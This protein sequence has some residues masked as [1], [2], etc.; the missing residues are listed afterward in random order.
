MRPLD[1]ILVLDLT[2]LLPGAAAT[3]WLANFGAEVIKVEQPGSGDY[4]RN[5]FSKGEDPIF[6]ATNRGKKSI[7]I[8][9]KDPR[10]RDVFLAL[11]PKADILIEGFRPRVM[12]RLGLGF[13]ELRKRNPSLICVALTGYG[14]DGPYSGM[15][16]HDINYLAL[17]GVL[18]LIGAKDGPPVIPGVQIADLAG[19][20]MQAVIGVLLALQARERTGRGQRVEISMTDGAAALLAVPLAGYQA[21]GR[22]PERGDELLSGRFACYNVY[23]ARDGRWVSVGAL[24]PKFWANLCRELALEHLVGEQFAAEPRRSEIKAA[25]AA[26]FRTRDAE[27]WFALL[28]GKDCCVAPVRNVAE[29][30]KDAHFAQHPFGLIPALSETPGRAGDRAPA[31]GEHTRETLRWAGISR[32]TL[33]ELQR[34]GVIQ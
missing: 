23:Q 9:L 17:A 16:G 8:D 19:G 6:T 7:A 4:A 11:V 32:E 33:E 13:E 25:V 12:E 1:G 26:V 31:L 20:S 21:T 22:A 2:R 15:A 24:E 29:A 30:V 5:L 14:S 18:D 3:M 10:G 28:G 34:E 27:E